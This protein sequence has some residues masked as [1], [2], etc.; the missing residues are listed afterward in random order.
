ML[1]LTSINCQSDM[2]FNYMEGFKI[3]YSC[4]EIEWKV[5]I[6]LLHGEIFL[7]FVVT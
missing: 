7:F 2:D 5:T 4:A 1:F 3:T 6:S